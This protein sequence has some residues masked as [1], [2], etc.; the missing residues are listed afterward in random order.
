MQTKETTLDILEM[1]LRTIKH[2]ID[3]LISGCNEDFNEYRKKLLDIFDDRFRNAENWYQNETKLAQKTNETQVVAI[4]NDFNQ[5][6]AEIKKVIHNQIMNKFLELEEC[7]PYHNMM[8]ITGRNDFVSNI[9]KAINQKESCIKIE[10]NRDPLIPEHELF[11]ETN[12][13]LNVYV[14]EGS[15]CINNLIFK[16]SNTCIVK[17][18][19][20]PP[21]KCIISSIQP[22]LIFLQ[23]DDMTTL[24]VPVSAISMNVISL[25]KT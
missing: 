2:N 13:A 10:E 16:E 20:Y 3:S 5:Q 11:I 25:T 1:E 7:L 6:A 17:V 9:I 19:N 14:N 12:N 21:F 23:T 15:L 8:K 18:S 22:K 24:R 4:E